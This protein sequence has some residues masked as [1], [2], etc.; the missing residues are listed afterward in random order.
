[1]GVECAVDSWNSM[2]DVEQGWLEQ[3]GAMGAWSLPECDRRPRQ[4]PGG[5][6][7]SFSSFGGGGRRWAYPGRAHIGPF[8]NVA[9]PYAQDISFLG[10][11]RE[12]VRT[13]GTL[14]GT[15]STLLSSL[16]W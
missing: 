14:F 13:S 12:L 6:G 10:I 7:R 15:A 3:Y 9:V 4:P 1:M 11:D 2:G 5:D 16:I 8:V